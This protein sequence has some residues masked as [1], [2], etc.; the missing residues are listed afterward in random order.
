MALRL[1]L[2][3]LD[4]S[5]NWV[6]MAAMLSAGPPRFFLLRVSDLGMPQ[7]QKCVR[8]RYL[9]KNILRRQRPAFGDVIVSLC[10]WPSAA[11]V[12]YNP[13]SCVTTMSLVL[14]RPQSRQFAKHGHL[15]QQV[16]RLQSPAWLLAT[17]RCF[18]VSGVRADCLAGS[19]PGCVRRAPRQGACSSR[20]S[21]ELD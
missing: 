2:S 19:T 11:T 20:C 9:A 17:A 6:A 7:S 18:P 12:S 15:A 10:P 8:F 21:L 4:L 5:R 1:P 13:G 3:G 16:F 14:G